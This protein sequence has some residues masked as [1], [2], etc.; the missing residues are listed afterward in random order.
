MLSTNKCLTALG[1]QKNRIGDEGAKA[2]A[3]ALHPVL[4]DNGNPRGKQVGSYTQNKYRGFSRGRGKSRRRTRQNKGG[5]RS[6]IDA[7]GNNTL[8][9]LDL[10]SNNIGDGGGWALGVAVARRTQ[11]IQLYVFNNKPMGAAMASALQ[12]RLTFEFIRR[13]KS[14][15]QMKNEQRTKERLRRQAE[16]DARKLKDKLKKKKRLA[17]ELNKRRCR[18]KRKAQVSEQLAMRIAGHLHLSNLSGVPQE[19]VNEQLRKENPSL[20]LMTPTEQ[21]HK[22]LVAINAYL[23]SAP[24]DSDAGDVSQH[25]PLLEAWKQAGCIFQEHGVKGGG[26]VMEMEYGEWGCT[27]YNVNIDYQRNGRDIN[28]GCVRSRGSFRGDDVSARGTCSTRRSENTRGSSRG[29][30]STRGSIDGLLVPNPARCTLGVALE[31]TGR[32]IRSFFDQIDDE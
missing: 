32:K 15:Q 10:S 23:D 5:D 31:R 27:D 8:V 26:L 6:G 11:K 1:L 21:L 7:P 25:R 3:Q 4:D 24:H 12:D 20:L 28:L 16:E 17:Q 30:A 18:N 29:K 19:A 22:I 13:S 9:E 2:L 14:E